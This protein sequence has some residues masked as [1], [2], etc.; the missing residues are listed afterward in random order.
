MQTIDIVRSLLG[1]KY[2]DTALRETIEAIVGADTKMGDLKHPV[3]IPTVNLTKGGPQFFK[4]PHHP[5]FKRDLHLK[6]SDVAMATSAAPTFFPLAEINDELFADGGLY[7][8]SPDLHALHEAEHFLEAE[9]S[10]IKMLSIGTTTTQF[11]FSHKI[12]RNLGSWAW[13]RGERFIRATISSQQI[14]TEFVMKHKLKDN[15]LRIDKVQSREQERD[16]TLD[17]ATDNAQKTIR[18]LADATYQDEI[19]NTVLKGMLSNKAK[20]PVFYDPKTEQ[21]I[22]SE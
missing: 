6:V 4:T 14:D 19:N 18:G 9:K 7:A 1:P 15:Y 17:V 12:G 8:N 10:T 16:L 21:P 13:A 3:I 2:K 11:S 5:S 22:A 20:T